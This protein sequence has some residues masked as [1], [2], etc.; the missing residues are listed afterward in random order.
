MRRSTICGLAG[1]TALLLAG[2]GTQPFQ[3]ADDTTVGSTQDPERR[4]GA[5]R[6]VRPA[7]APARRGDARRHRARPPR[8]VDLLVRALGARVLL[9]RRDA[10]GRPA[11]AR[12]DHRRRGGDVPVRRLLVQ[13]GAQP[14]HPSDPCGAGFPAELEPTDDHRWTLPAV[15]PAGTY[16]VE[17]QRERSGG[18]RRRDVRDDHDARRRGAGADRRRSTSSSTTT[19]RSR[20]RPA[21]APPG[22]AAHRRRSSP[23]P[24]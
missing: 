13:R 15:G 19:V 21:H 4:G 7:R 5:G 1:A 22:R 2:C 9:R 14:D 17:S 20:S 3:S 24:S 16:V 11:H 18:Q 23:A 8:V 6:G 12:R 10:A